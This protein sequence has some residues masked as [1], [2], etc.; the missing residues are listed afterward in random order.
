M[1]NLQSS[2]SAFF[3][4]GGLFWGWLASPKDDSAHM[5]AIALYVLDMTLV[6]SLES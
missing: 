3:S 5:F 4:V 2:V 1:G 6:N